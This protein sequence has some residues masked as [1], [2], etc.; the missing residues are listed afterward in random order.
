ME[1]TE[2]VLRGRI[3]S[4]KNSKQVICFG[5]VPR[6]IP[7]AKHKEWHTEASV[8]LQNQKPITKVGSIVFILYAPDNRKG[9]LSNKWE[10]VADLLVD[11]EIIEDDNWFVMQDVRMVFGGVD[12]ENPRAVV[13]VYPQFD[14]GKLLDYNGD[15]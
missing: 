3:P 15:V 5:K 6:L 10:S 2:I 12:K 13:R 7:S 4:K 9:D 8:A 14:I 1:Y 11:L